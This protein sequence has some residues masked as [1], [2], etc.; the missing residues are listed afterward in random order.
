MK[1]RDLLALFGG[2][3]ITV[4]GC[5][6]MLSDRGKTD[7]PLTEQ[8]NSSSDGTDVST[9]GE[10]GTVTPTT[11]ETS[12]SGECDSAAMPKWVHRP[13]PVGEGWPETVVEA[14]SS[15][16]EN[17]E[18][19]VSVVEQF[20]DG[21]PAAIRISFLNTSCS[22]MR[23]SFG[24]TPPFARYYNTGEN[25]SEINIVPVITNEHLFG[26][27]G[28]EDLVPIAK[29]EECWSVDYGS[30]QGFGT[31][32]EIPAG[33]IVTRTYLVFNNVNNEECLPAGE[34]RYELDPYGGGE[35]SWGFTLT[36]SY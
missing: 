6:G 5:T 11:A 12:V 29:E 34:Y 26:G 27:E 32:L 16:Y 17:V 33:G 36:L 7:A 9:T 14:D 4:A 19:D 13:L 18:L 35:E 8:S 28:A 23:A 1:R 15:P 20:T 10:T 21:S 3:T 2:G 22:T 30:S 24:T 25:G 31:T